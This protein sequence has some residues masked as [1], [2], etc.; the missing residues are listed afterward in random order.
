MRLLAWVILWL[1]PATSFVL[2]P[3]VR[4]STTLKATN[5]PSLPSRRDV[6]DGFTAVST[7]LA[8]GSALWPATALAAE[9]MGSSASAPIVVLGAGGKVGK[10][11]VDLLAQSGRYVK[12][13]TRSG[14]PV[15]DDAASPYVLYAAGD[16]TSAESVKN[17]VQG[18]SGVIFTASASGKS[19]G[20]DPAHVDYLGVYNTAQACLAAKVPKLALVSAGTVT[21]P[22]SAGFKATNFFVQYIYGPNIMGYKMAGEA[23]VRD[24]YAAAPPGIAY[25]IIRPGGLNEKP[26]VGPTKLHV[27]QGDVYSSEVTRQDVARTTVAALL[28]P[29]A[30]N[31][32]LE[33]N[34]IEGLG[35]VLKTLPDLPAE[36]VHAGAPSYEALLEGLL[37]DQ[38]MAAKY[39]QLLNDFRGGDDI[40]PIEQLV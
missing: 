5:E 33:L 23:T 4:P 35:K 16:V 37:S 2:Q 38:A 15:L 11:C 1:V 40:V 36:L 6:L 19:K 18:A 26:S 21:R 34:Q 22:D 28:S 39:P 24:L 12:A 8:F 20:G 25:T 27:S 32:T 7:G 29:A 10:I 3:V 30:D 31:A 9:G 17:A 13:V 14:Q